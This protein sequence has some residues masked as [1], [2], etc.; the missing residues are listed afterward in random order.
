MFKFEHI[1]HLYALALIPVVILFYVG[2]RY[3]RKRR[4]D[5]LGDRSLVERLMPE[6]SRYKHTVKFLL[7]LVAL[8]T[9]I[10]GWANP[11]W[12]TKR[13]KVNRKSIDVFIALDISQSMLAQDIPP[14][15]LERAQKFAQDLVRKLQGE[16][17][18]V[19]IF[20]GNAYLQIPLTTDYGA[21]YQF[22]GDT[23]PNMVSAQGTAI[24][25]AIELAESSFDP[26]NQ[27]HKALIVISDG[28]NHEDEA[29]QLARRASNNGLIIYSIGVG[30]ENGSFIPTFVGGRS[31]FKRDQTGNPVRTKINEK[32]LE[33]LA[34]AGNGSYYNLTYDNAQI[35]EDVRNQLNDIEKREFEQRVFSEFE[36]YFQYFIGISLILIVAEFLISYRRSGYMTGRD[37]FKT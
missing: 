21:C 1:D 23:N 9:L 13:E 20:A 26:E 30:T 10:I 32:M 2:M 16:R 14:S 6:A 11:Q 18:G 15:R 35:L 33:D 22:I 3:W 5:Q 7:L 31:D 17:I 25:D 8:S 36:S 29:M 37:L 24:S 19:I 34:S 28:E 27:N 12:G 4:L